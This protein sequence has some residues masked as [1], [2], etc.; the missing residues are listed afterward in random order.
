MEFPARS[1]RRAEPSSDLGKRAAAA[2]LKAAFPGARCGDLTLRA[3]RYTGRSEKT[4]RNWLDGTHDMKLGD[5]LSLLP[6]IGAETA[7]KIIYGQKG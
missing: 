6:L 4:I 5:A 1:I 3:S 7:L 2:L